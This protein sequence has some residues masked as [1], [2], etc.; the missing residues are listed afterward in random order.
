MVGEESGT[1]ARSGS[2]GLATVIG[3]VAGL[4]LTTRWGVLPMV[5]AAGLCGLLV[6]VSEKVARARQRP[7]QIPALWARIVMSTAIAAPLGW[8]LGAVPGARTII[9]GLL[10]GGLVGALGLRP[11]KVVLGPLVGLA[12]GFGCQLL[13]DDV[14]AAIVA[15]AT[16]LAFRT[17]SAGIFRDPQ[18]MLLAERVSAE[19]L[20]FVVPLVARTRY[21]GTAYV[22][23]L[24]EV[25][26]GEYQAAAADVGIV[27]SLAELAGP[28]FDPAAADPLVRE[29]YEHTTRFALD[30]VPRWR[31]WVRP[32][33][34]LYRTLLARP[35]GQAN[36]PMNQREAQRGVHS[37]ID[38]ISRASDGIVSIRGWIRSYVDNDEPIYVGI[39][40]TYRRDGRG[41]VSVGFP[42][43]QAS[44]TATLAPRGRPGGGLVLT[45]RGDLDQPGH[46]LTYVDAETG[47]LTAAAVHGFAEQLAVYVQNGEL[48]AEHEFWVF[49]LPF[50]VLHY[51]IRRKPELG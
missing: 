43:P 2:V 33:Y 50:L 44:F 24:A 26:G 13:W 1:A 28:E 34:L 49:G 16:V 27:A 10:V 32:G 25:L 23:D 4:S 18:V 17:L 19:D 21:V 38:T 15:S 11:Q 9:I 39:Y 40:T 3:A 20:P 45:S 7:G 6:T 37:R 48:R 5:V 47:E 30:I 46:Y 41:Y 22:R 35:L 31:L 51:T 12:V 36:V 14:P 42:L 8:V 29:F